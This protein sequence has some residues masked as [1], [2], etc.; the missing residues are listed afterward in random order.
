MIIFEGRFLFF[1]SLERAGG[2][3]PGS[4][5]F[6]SQPSLLQNIIEQHPRGDGQIK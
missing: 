6:N 4:Q 5:R 2:G 1:S 3:V